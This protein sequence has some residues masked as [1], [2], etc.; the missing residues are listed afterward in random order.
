MNG[1]D[2]RALSATRE[3]LERWRK[4]RRDRGCWIPEELWNEAVEVARAS[5][6]E[7]TAQA[8]G[9]NH[10]R[11]QNWMNRD[12]RKEIVKSEPEAVFVEMGPLCSWRTVVE[13]L[14]RD[15]ERMR[16]EVTGPS[17]VDIAGLSRTFWSRQP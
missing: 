7:A 3:K 8:L 17:A 5:G 11:L 12:E 15:G 2:A 6:A 10:E 13:L 1:S 4:E 16:I 9:L 14:G